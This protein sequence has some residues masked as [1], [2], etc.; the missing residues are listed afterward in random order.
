MSCYKRIKL[1][2]HF[3]KR[4]EIKVMIFRSRRGISDLAKVEYSPH[5]Q[6]K[7]LILQKLSGNNCD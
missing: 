1:S 5:Q 4:S 2:T 6:L 3:S 7:S